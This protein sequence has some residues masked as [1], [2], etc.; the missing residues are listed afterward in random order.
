[1][2]DG[3]LLFKLEHLDRYSIVKEPCTIIVK[4]NS[5]LAMDDLYTEDSSPRWI[6]NLKVISEFNLMLLKELSKEGERLTYSDMGHLLMTGAIWE[7]QIGTDADLPSK[8][9]ELI[10]V[11]GYVKDILMCTNITLIPRRQP[12]I[13]L[14]SSESMNEINEFE[15]I[16]KEMRNEK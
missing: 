1:M 11:F 5:R 14:Y 8:G 2:K 4:N 3:S 15:K 9:E 12:D 6:L 13:Y 16:I 10:A 7:D